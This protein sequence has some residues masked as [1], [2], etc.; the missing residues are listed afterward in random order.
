M[1]PDVEEEARRLIREYPIYP[2]ADTNWD[3]EWQTLCDYFREHP[4]ITKD[5]LTQ[6]LLDESRKDGFG[7]EWKDGLVMAERILLRDQTR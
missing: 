4:E 1:I 2:T 3:R 7:Y 6:M 5:E